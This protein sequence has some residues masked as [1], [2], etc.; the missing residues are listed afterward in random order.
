MVYGGLSQSETDGKK[1]PYEHLMRMLAHPTRCLQMR[2][3]MK[4]CWN[5]EGQILV[6]AALSLIVLLTVVFG[7][8][9]LGL[10]LYAYNFV[11]EAARKGSR[12]A[13][14]RGSEAATPGATPVSCDGAGSAGSGYAPLA[15]NWTKF[16]TKPISTKSRFPLP[17]RGGIG[18]SFIVHCASWQTS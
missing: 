5:G 12:D 7:I 1:R 14:V 8:M 3:A 11:S 15:R 6:E 4:R 9:G 16:W 17:D 2:S 18:M 13:M 10:A